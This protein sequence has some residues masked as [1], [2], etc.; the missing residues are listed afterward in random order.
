MSGIRQQFAVYVHFF[1]HQV[2]EVLKRKGRLY[3]F[4]GD[5]AEGAFSTGEAS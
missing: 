1:E 5:V 4:D 3:L 2:V